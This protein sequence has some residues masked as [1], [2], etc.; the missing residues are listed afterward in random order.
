MSR[1]FYQLFTLNQMIIKRIE[2]LTSKILND[3]KL[4]RVP[5]DVKQ[6]ASK[7]GLVIRSFD[8]GENISGMLV[9]ENGRGI[10]SYNPNE[11]P[12]RQRF[13]IAHELGHYELH[14]KANQVFVDKKFQYLFRNERSS[15]GID[16]LEQEANAFAA[17]LLM[18]KHLI[19][20]ELKK[21]DFDYADEIGLKE[22][23]KTFN[24]STQ[25]MSFRLANLGLL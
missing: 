6:V 12:L 2:T 9:V 5:V 4:Q 11:S 15:Q 24:V 23:A 10:I 25:A 18:P 7:L 8:L 13:T 16:F 20:E 3:L 22:L 14:Q 21:H 1:D 19:L 17:S